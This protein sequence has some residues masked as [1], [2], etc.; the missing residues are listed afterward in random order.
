MSQST[1]K[2]QRPLTKTAAIIRSSRHIIR[3]PFFEIKSAPIACKHADARCIVVTPKAV[4]NA[5]QRNKIKRRIR[6]AYRTLNL[7][8]T[9]RHWIFFCKK[10]CADYSYQELYQI[11]AEAKTHAQNSQSNS[12]S[13]GAKIHTEPESSKQDT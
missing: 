4:G 10:G 6:F 5:V 13:H 11:I 1:K 8:E 7:N 12:R 9:Q 3:R 2:R